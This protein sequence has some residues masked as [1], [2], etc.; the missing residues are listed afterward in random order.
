MECRF[1]ADA[2]YWVSLVFTAIQ[3][4]AVVE[5]VFICGVQT[6]LHTVF[7]NLTGTRRTL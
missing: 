5:D 2:A 7:H 1:G 3:L 4:M 6:G